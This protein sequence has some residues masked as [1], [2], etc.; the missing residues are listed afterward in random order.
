[1]LATNV[2]ETSLTVPGIR[3]VIDTGY[4]RVKRY[5]Y[6]NKVEQLQIEKISQ[7][8]ANQRAGRCGRVAAGVCVRLYDEE[9]FAA[10]EFTDPEILRSSLA[11]VILRMKALRLGDVEEFPFVEAPTPRMISRRLPAAARTRRGRRAA[12]ELTPVAR[13]LA[14]M[15]LDPRI[16]R[17][18]VAAKRRLPARGA[19]HRRR[20]VGAGPARAA[21]G[22]SRSRRP[23]HK[24]I[25]PTSARTFIAYLKLWDFFG[26]EAIETQASP[27]ANWRSSW[28]EL[29]VAARMREWR[30]IHGQL[31]AVAAEL[32]WQEP[33]NSRRLRRRSTARCSP[34]CW[35]TS[36]CKSM[37]RAHYLGARGIKFWVH[38]GSG[39]RRRPASGSSPPRSAR[40][41]ASSRAASRASSRSGWSRSARTC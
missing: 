10:A 2:A 22:A 21:D 9:D 36:A 31:H 19:G 3:Y 8:S 28:R 1:V 18:I 16:A 40:R 24:R 14:Q 5:S 23:A 25:S 33:T 27:T 17:M 20:A 38:P 37:R 39:C 30:D 41:R 12:S 32:G 7:A 11:S 6:R 15:P 13:Q 26:I 34:G 35:A 4:A 29:P